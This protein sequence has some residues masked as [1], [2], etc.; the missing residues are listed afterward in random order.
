MSAA[1]R[2]LLLARAVLDL[3]S[4]PDGLDPLEL[5]HDLTDY[6]VRLARVQSAGVT[7][8]DETGHVDYLTASDTVCARLEEAQLDLDEGPCVD[9][10][11]TGSVLRP[12]LLHPA[13]AAFERWPRFTPWALAAGYSSVAAVPLRIRE[14]SLGSLNLLQTGARTI[15]SVDLHSAQLLADAAGSRLNHQQTLLDRD[16][17]ITQLTS[18]LESRIV[19]E[20]AK[21][22]MAARLGIDVDDAFRRMRALARSR[23]QK[24]IDL[25]RQITQGSIPADADRTP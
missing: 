17:V 14:D 7:V 24:L 9:S 20:Q 10:A 18:A 11:R 19:I 5:L 16:E 22:M 15:S 8:L 13:D 21:G 25:A 12:V 4:R 6:A 2:D 23:Q 3:A 1:P